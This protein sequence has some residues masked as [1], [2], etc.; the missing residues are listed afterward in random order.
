MAD[1][2]LAIDQGTTSSRAIVFDRSAR[3]VSSGQLEHD[4]IFPRAGWVE[5]DPVQIWDNVREAVGIALTRANLT[6]QD[7]ACVGVTNQRETT[8]VWDRHTGIPVTNAIVWQDTRTQRIVDEFAGTVGVDRYRPIVGLPL[9]TYFSG[10]KVAWILQNIDGARE[11]ADRGDLLFG[12][13]DT[14]VLWNLTGGLDGGMH[15]TDVTNASR[16]MLMDLQTLSWREDIAEDMGIPLSMLPE[17]RSSSEVYGQGRAHGMLPGVPIAGILG[18]QQAATFGQ[19]CFSEGMAKNTY[20]TGNFVLLN[21]GERRVLSANGLLTTVCY[22][23]GD[24][25]QIYALEGSIAVTGSLVQWLRDNLGMFTDAPDIEKLALQVEDNGGAY[26]VPAFSGLFAPYWR[27][28]ARGALLGLTRYVTKN[29]IARAALEA[30]AFQTRE[31]MDAMNADAGVELAELRVDGGMVG[32]ELLMQFQADQLGVDVIRPA[33][34]ETTA[35]G[36]AF[37]AG[38]AVGF[39]AGTQDVTDNWSEDKRW[40]PQMPRLE[41]DRLYR[42]WKKAVTK[43][44]GWVDGDVET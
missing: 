1:Y 17:I 7:I 2:V 16:T 11:A 44:M 12:T 25:P 29:H 6:Y 3:I 4:Q 41:R 13:M 15:I 26:F 27:Q 14:W 22:K 36:A 21:T 8:V 38:I 37:A 10:P 20:G 28:D 32:N 18:D 33:V 24:A 9:A 5:H 39:W 34:T 30:T 35:L 43:T 42:N 23:L 40:S 19:A 31:V